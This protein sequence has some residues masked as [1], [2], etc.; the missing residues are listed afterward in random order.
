M[1]NFKILLGDSNMHPDLRI[2]DKAGI[3]SWDTDEAING[4]EAAV[5]H[6]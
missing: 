1:G 5:N 3:T 4:M 2:T 6:F